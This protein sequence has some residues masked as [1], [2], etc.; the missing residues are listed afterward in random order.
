MDDDSNTLTDMA[1]LRA[2]TAS[3]SDDWFHAPPITAVSLRLSDETI[4]VAVS[5]RLEGATCQPH[6]CVCNVMVDKTSLHGLFCKK[7]APRH[8][9]F[10]Q[11]N[12]VIWRAV[13]RAQYPSEKEPLKSGKKSAISVRK[14]AS[15]SITVRRHKTERNNS[16]TLDM[17][18]AACMGHYSRRHVCHFV[19]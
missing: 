16:H 18:Q 12:D 14:G 3:H 9:H 1:R 13:K 2:A 10:A 19:R 6:S 15:G 5:Y 11:L 17:R 4:R 7:F 8:I